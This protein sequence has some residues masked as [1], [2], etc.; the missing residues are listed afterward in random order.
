MLLNTKF[1]KRYRFTAPKYPENTQQASSG[2]HTDIAEPSTP[3][4]NP[5]PSQRV[6][7]EVQNS[8]I[9]LCFSNLEEEESYQPRALTSVTVSS[10]ETGRSKVCASTH[11]KNIAPSWGF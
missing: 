3:Q 7:K 1:S 2:E 10:E 11:S 8:R 9:V 5:E 6:T 4:E